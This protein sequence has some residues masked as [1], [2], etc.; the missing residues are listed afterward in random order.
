M[1]LKGYICDL[2]RVRRKL[3]QRRRQKICNKL[4]EVAQICRSYVAHILHVDR[5]LTSKGSNKKFPN[6]TQSNNEY[7]KWNNRSVKG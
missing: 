5:W 6:I 3:V 2:Y 1:L 7:K 4:N